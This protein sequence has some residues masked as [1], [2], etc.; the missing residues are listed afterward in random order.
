MNFITMSDFLM[1][2]IKLEDLSPELLGNANTIVP[3]A[4]DLLSHFGEFR[5]CNS[6]F[7]SAADQARINP[8]APHSKHME[9]AAI[10]LEDKDG[11]LKH[12]CVN[13]QA[14]LASI[15]LWMESPDHTPTWLHVQCV[16]PK[17]GNRI[18]IP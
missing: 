8:S 7:R 4:N 12:F 14:L 18:F 15:G 11:K 1:N 2:R 6:G 3:R 9:A 13:N 10:D 16:P 17:S 5:A